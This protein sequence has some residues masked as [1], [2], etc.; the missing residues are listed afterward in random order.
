MN[1]NT[2]QKTKEI[3]FVPEIELKKKEIRRHGLEFADVDARRCEEDLIY[4]IMMNADT[5][6]LD[7]YVNWLCNII[8]EVHGRGFTE[9][10]MAKLFALN[11]KDCV[12]K[13]A[14]FF[15]CLD[16]LPELLSFIVNGSSGD[17]DAGI[18]PTP[19]PKL[20][21]KDLLI[22]YCVKNLM[23]LCNQLMDGEHDMVPFA[24]LCSEEYITNVGYW[25]EPDEDEDVP[26][27]SIKRRK[28]NDPPPATPNKI[29]SKGNVISIQYS[30]L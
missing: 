1:P 22:N 18:Q 3:A 6:K 23:P 14:F 25:R 19:P 7:S 2:R 28:K 16:T 29:V 30:S 26:R 21:N 17:P 8:K 20:L 5:T 27:T 13:K 9:Q 12:T 11:E 4:D 10:L 24:I 15:F